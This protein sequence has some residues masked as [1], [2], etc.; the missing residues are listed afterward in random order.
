MKKSSKKYT[1]GQV[2]WYHTI[3]WM[4]P[5][6]ICFIIAGVQLCNLKN[7]Y[8][9]SDSCVQDFDN[10]SREE[11]ITRYTLIDIQNESQ[12]RTE[13]FLGLGFGVLFTLIA[14]TYNHHNR[15]LR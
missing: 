12:A 11:C 9:L 10:I 14:V 13:V 3:L 8:H 15:F 5:A 7:G 4:L 1:P 2:I 6:I